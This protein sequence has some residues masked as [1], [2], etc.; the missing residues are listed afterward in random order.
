MGRLLERKYH[1]L[2]NVF[3]GETLLCFVVESR[4]LDIIVPAG[5]CEVSSNHTR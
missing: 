1:G 3:G 5:H 4:G 2:G